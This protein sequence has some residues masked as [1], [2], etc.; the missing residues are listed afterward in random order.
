MKK[1]EVTSK[2][3]RK[4]KKRYSTKWH[5]QKH[6]KTPGLILIAKLYGSTKT[7]NYIKSYSKK[8]WELFYNMDSAFV[9]H[10]DCS[11]SAALVL[12]SI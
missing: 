6:W 2:I 12:V 8:N 11:N 3:Y 1:G 5:V 4:K 9:G 10:D 7:F